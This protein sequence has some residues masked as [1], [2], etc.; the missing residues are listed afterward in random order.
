MAAIAFVGCDGAIVRHNTIY[1]PTGWIVRILQETTGPDFVPCRNGSF[2]HNI[3][4]FRSDEL[5]TAVNIGPNTE[6]KSFTF[7]ENHWYCMD[8]PPRSNRI[9]LPVTESNGSYGEDPQF[10]NVRQGDLRL[11]ETSPVKDA[12]V[13]KMSNSTR[14]R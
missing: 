5:R 6:P 14:N 13:R 11:K 3:V 4:V 1:R 7:A 2:M 8:D 10:K 9:S 12:G